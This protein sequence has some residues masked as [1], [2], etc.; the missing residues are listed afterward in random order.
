MALL[1]ALLLDPSAIARVQG[2]APEFFYM[3]QHREIFRAMLHLVAQGKP[4][5]LTLVAS[6]LADSGKL[7]AAG[8]QGGL[9]RLVDSVISSANVDLFAEL[10]YTKWLRRRLITLGSEIS[11]LAWEEGGNQELLARAHEILGGLSGCLS[12]NWKSLAVMAL[13]FADD[14]QQ[15]LAGTKSAGIPTGLIDLDRR[16]PLEEKTLTLIA[17]RPGM[18]KSAIAANIAI[19]MALDGRGVV[20]VSLEMGT[21]Q[22]M[23]RWLS[24]H[25]GIEQ[26]KIKH[27]NLS[28]QEQSQIEGLMLTW[29]KAAPNLHFLE[30]GQVSSASDLYSKVLAKLPEVDANPGCII[31]DH[32]HL[33]GDGTEQVGAS[34]AM[35]QTLSRKTTVPVIALCQLSRGPEGQN[36]KRPS[37][38]HLRYSGRLEQDAD[39]IWLLYRDEYYNPETRDRNII[40]INAAKVREGSPGVSKLLFE[41][42]FS[43]VRNLAGGLR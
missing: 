16:S 21:K 3:G 15:I 20:F 14:L 10:I 43:R 27:G 23:R 38:A 7:E 29:V 24:A 12:G 11:Q 2:L 22:I 32:L 33:L 41:P 31:I 28:T 6:A 9:A 26:E 30:P 5:D 17:G 19:N 4:T 8:G 42:Q 34:S 39:N 37:M 35:A 1:G 40:E 36:D 13:E 25:S 18:G